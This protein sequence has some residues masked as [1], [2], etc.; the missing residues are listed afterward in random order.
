M[1]FNKLPI[2]SDG[3]TI[4]VL[5]GKFVIPNNPIIPFI[6]G[7]GTGRDIW[8]ASRQVFTAAVEAAY[9]GK[10]RSPGMKSLQAKRPTTSFKAGCPKTH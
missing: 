6:E 7:D 3:E 2:P 4:E 8:K 1:T 5:N 10:K 9:S